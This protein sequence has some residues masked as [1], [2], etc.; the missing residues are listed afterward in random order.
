MARK[1]IEKKSRK[2]DYDQTLFEEVGKD[3]PESF[4]LYLNNNLVRYYLS[5]DSITCINSIRNVNVLD[6]IGSILHDGIILS[7][8]HIFNRALDD[9]T[10]KEV[11]AYPLALELHIPRNMSYTTKL[12]LVNNEYDISVGT[13]SDYDLNTHIC[14]IYLGM[15]P[16]SY[17][18]RM[19]FRTKEEQDVF[20]FDFN[21]IRTPYEIF[22]VSQD[23]FIGGMELDKDRIGASYSEFIKG[24]DL[25]TELIVNLVKKRDKVRGF[26]FGFFYGTFNSTQRL[27]PSFDKCVLDFSQFSESERTEA[28][29]ALIESFPT[30]EPVVIGSLFRSRQNQDIYGNL[31]LLLEIASCEI[32]EIHNKV[33]LSNNFGKIESRE[34]FV[35]GFMLRKLFGPN[36]SYSGFQDVILDSVRDLTSHITD[37]SEVYKWFRDSLIFILEDVITDRISISKV[38]EN[39]SENTINSMRALMILSKASYPNEFEKL[40][41]NVNSFKVD[42]SLGRLTMMVYGALNGVSSFSSDFKKNPFINRIIDQV[43]GQFLKNDFIIEAAPD[44]TDFMSYRRKEKDTYYTKSGLPITIEIIQTREERDIER[45]AKYVSHIF[46]SNKTRGVEK[47]IGSI[48]WKNRSRFN[49][50]IPS[51]ITFERDNVNIINKDEFGVSI[52]LNNPKFSVDIDMERFKNETILE[53]KELVNS[54]RNNTEI[55]IEIVKKI[56]TKS[57]LKVVS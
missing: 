50:N 28:V 13:I 35:L 30:I 56:K 44:L 23:H 14:M 15:I 5:L 51:I 33:Y 2:R 18:S 52:M 47:I 3:F 25:P 21:N 54:V 40:I 6:S 31:N 9:E 12:L 39:V 48:I 43:S 26:L 20:G 38:L 42:A 29:S 1:A 8:T 27:I 7:H 46:S 45:I 36:A 53:Q 19:L 57:K 16:F 32:S 24:N 49:G 34:L 11:N 22:E 10:I 41:T 55:W 17:V 4:F 37:D